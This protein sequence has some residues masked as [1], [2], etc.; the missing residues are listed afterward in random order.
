MG[1]E[2]A[3]IISRVG[4][5]GAARGFVVGD[6]VMCLLRQLHFANRAIADWTS[7]VAMLNEITC[8]E[9]A[10]IPSAFFSAY[11]CLAEVARLKLAQRVLIHD[12]A[13]D[14]GQAAIMIAQ[15]IGGEVFALVENDKKRESI[16]K[17]YGI[18]LDQIFEN[19]DSSFSAAVLE[20]TEGRG[21][22]VV[23]SSRAGPL[24]EAISLVAPQGWFIQLHDDRVGPGPI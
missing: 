22:D 20:A 2:C 4:S 24:R 23:L 7:V 10:S 21:V 15:H 3:G 12:A 19:A 11:F 18:P 14:I 1:L 16:A 13:E 5:E 9:A 6:R 17:G 8:D